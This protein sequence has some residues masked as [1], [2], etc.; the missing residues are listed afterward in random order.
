[1]KA[2]VNVPVQ[3]SEQYSVIHSG[4]FGANL[5]SHLT[6]LWFTLSMCP[7]LRGWQSS[8]TQNLNSGVSDLTLPFT[9]HMN[10]LWVQN[11]AQ[12]KLSV[13]GG[14]TAWWRALTWHT[15]DPGYY[16]LST[17]KWVGRHHKQRWKVCSDKSQESRVPSLTYT[18]EYPRGGGGL[19]RSPRTPLFM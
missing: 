2:C 12:P 4:S 7:G 9:S 11:H 6:V 10:H 5:C 17:P 16:S 19:R 14:R 15:W 8:R 1:M 13:M 18:A 3:N